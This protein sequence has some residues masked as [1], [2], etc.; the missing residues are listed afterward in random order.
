M[1]CSST[2]IT[3]D[4]LLVPIAILIKSMY[5]IKQISKQILLEKAQDNV[6]L[7][8]TAAKRDVMSLLVRAQSTN[9]S[10]GYHMSEEAM[11]DQ[12]LTFLGAGHETT[13]SGLAWVC[14]KK[15]HSLWSRFSSSHADFLVTCQTPGSASKA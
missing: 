13:A 2:F 4:A 10:E 3:N 14:F 7:E 11:I 5:R 15:N 9:K 1:R 8:D 12:V 6:G